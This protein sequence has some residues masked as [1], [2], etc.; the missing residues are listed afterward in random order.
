MIFILRS[1][2]V[3]ILGILVCVVGVVFCLFNPRNPNNV[4]RFA[5]IFG[6]VFTPLFGIKLVLRENQHAT[7]NMSR[8][9]IANHQN[10]YDILVAGQIVQKGTVT[11]GKKSLVWIPF[12]GLLYWITGN[13]LLDRENKS[14]ARD[15]LALVVR[16]IAKKKIS[17]WMFP[18]GTRSKGRGLLPFKTG[19]FRTAIAAGVPIVPI[20]VS[21]T[22]NIKLNRWNNGYM[23]VEMLE[24]ISTND[25][26]KE[27]A[28]TLMSHCHQIMDEKIKQLDQEVIVLNG[29]K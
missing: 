12:F 6:K 10:N 25:M 16:E 2:I 4:A 20:C 1:I 26:A 13:I 7:Q 3:L 9:F 8:I 23:I 24:P 28:R 22:N 5:H 15:T 14:K 21:N 19:A 18:E 27:D 17:I 11:V 29:S